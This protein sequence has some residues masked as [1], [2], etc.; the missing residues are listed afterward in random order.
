MIAIH[1]VHVIVNETAGGY[2]PSS[3]KNLISSLERFSPKVEKTTGPG[4]ALKMAAKVDEGGYIVAVGGDGTLH[5]IIQSIKSRDITLIPAG[6]GSGSDLQKTT[7]ILSA[8]DIANGIEGDLGSWIDTIRISTDEAVTYCANIMEI[9][10]GAKVMRRVNRRGRTLLNPFTSAVLHEITRMD[11]YDVSMKIDAKEYSFRTPEIIIANCRFFG[12]G[13]L[14]SPESIPDDGM[15]EL[16]VI[17]N[18]S[19]LGLLGN[20]RKLRNGAYTRMDSVVNA[21]FTELEVLSAGLPMEADGELIG[22][23]PCK[24]E[25][26]PHS[27]KILRG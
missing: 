5:E 20:L 23:T 1:A 18:T 27:L 9:G 19:R 12:S 16:H 8:E 6:G 22:M 24:I 2:S 17:K 11:V 7:G 13:M 15:L 3:T 26:A 21:T 10:L 14:A 25:V 4:D